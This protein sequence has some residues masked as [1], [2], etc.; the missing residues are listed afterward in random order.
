MK[1]QADKTKREAKKYKKSNKIILSMK[2][3]VS[4]ESLVK[5]LMDQ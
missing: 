5:K 1:W 2:D 3:L 4:K